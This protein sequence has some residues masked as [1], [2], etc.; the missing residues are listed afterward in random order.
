M[1]TMISNITRIGLFVRLPLSAL[2]FAFLG[3]TG[4][5]ECKTTADCKLG[6]ICQSGDCVKTPGFIGTEDTLSDEE[7]DDSASTDPATETVDTGT[8]TG[9]GDD[10]ASTSV[11]TDDSD[12]S[13]VSVCRDPAEDCPSVAS[14]CRYYV[15]EADRCVPVDAEDG[16]FCTAIDNACVDGMCLAGQCVAVPLSGTACE[17]DGNPCTSDVCKAGACTHPPL[18]NGA[19]CEDDGNPCTEDVCYSG[20]CGRPL[21]GISCAEGVDVCASA[22]CESGECKVTNAADNTPC[23]DGS[24]CNGTSDRCVSGVCRPRDGAGPCEVAGACVRGNCIE[25]AEGELVGQCSVVDLEGHSCDDGVFC[26][27]EETCVE[28]ECMS[29]SK[30]CGENTTGCATEVCDEVGAECLMQNKTD[31]TPCPNQ[32]GLN[33]NGFEKCESG[34]CVSGAPFCPIFSD[35]LSY[36]CDE[37]AGDPVCNEDPTY[38]ADGIECGSSN[39]CEGEGTRLCVAGLCAEG[40]NPICVPVD[41]DGNLCSRYGTCVY[42]EDGPRC[43]FESSTPD[44]PP[45]EMLAVACGET[46]EFATATGH[47]EIAGYNAAQCA[48][49]FSGGEVPVLVSVDSGTAYTATITTTASSVVGEKLYMALVTNVCD[50]DDTCLQVSNTTLSST[51]PASGSHYIIIDGKGGNRGTGTLTITCP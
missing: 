40:E 3:A 1:K 9:T 6:Q 22:Q 38:A 27:G 20:V 18:S 15:C 21:S 17:D 43:L 48:G 16:S 34:V 28:G 5:D 29:M 25:P 45:E 49:D 32:D 4:C 2:A 46:V 14:E 42:G 23:D 41:Q 11:G 37:N 7:T 36:D 39:L 13:S 12:S 33:C 31:G 35:C 47:N 50:A 8:G 26:N 51:V 24:W 44:T 30:P 10:T 19:V